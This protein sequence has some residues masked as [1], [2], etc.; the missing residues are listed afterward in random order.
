[1]RGQDVLKR[2]T[3]GFAGDGYYRFW[4]GVWLT[5]AVF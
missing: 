2:P 4:H 3:L 5:A 1:M